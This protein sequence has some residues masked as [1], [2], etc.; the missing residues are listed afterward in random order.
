MD[1]NDMGRKIDLAQQRLEMLLN[2]NKTGELLLQPE[3]LCVILEELSISIE[4]LQVQH[5]EILETR[6]LLEIERQR[7]QELFDLAPDSYLITDSLGMIRKINYATEVLF[8]APSNLIVNKPLASFIEESDRQNFRTKLNELKQIK[9][10]KDWE[11]RLKPDQLNDFPASISVSSMYNYQGIL[12]GF[13]W[14]IRDLISCKQNELEL[15]KAKENAEAA[16]LAKETFLAVTSH[17]L[18][19]PLT[20]ILGFCSLFLNDHLSPTQKTWIETIDNSAKILLNII[21]DILDFVKIE[22][23]KIELESNVF[24]LN[25]CIEKIVQIVAFSAAKKGIIIS[26]NLSEDSPRYVRGDE[27]KLKQV[28]INLLNNA[29]KFTEKGSINISVKVTKK[30]KSL[31]L[32]FAIKDTGIGIPHDRLYRLF[33]PFSQVDSSTSRKYGG[34]G[35]GLA[36]CQKLVENMGGK[37]WVKSTPNQGSTFYFTLITP[38]VTLEEEKEYLRLEKVTSTTL[39]DDGLLNHKNLK[40]LLVEDD[41][42]IS[43]LLLCLFSEMGIEVDQVKNGKEAVKYW[44]ENFYDLIFM[45]LQMPIMDGLTATRLIREEEQT[46]QLQGRTK[47]IGLTANLREE[48]KK[49][50]LKSGMDDYISKPF[51]LQNLINL[52]KSLV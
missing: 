45:D 24:A 52:L 14:Q 21:E 36:I 10:L 40:I 28:L 23:G 6:Q 29:V 16:N 46:R 11:V 33:K 49:D 27:R 31:T 37:I 19:T 5:Q 35:L 34:T 43:D 26:Y 44:Q 41:D 51:D 39:S 13:R 42:S 3:L 50:C 48:I 47:I 8:N 1:T 15:I 7:Y 20:A 32:E 12:E 9:Q 25:L 17:E 2:H 4:E 38:Q 30:E 18:R 22:M